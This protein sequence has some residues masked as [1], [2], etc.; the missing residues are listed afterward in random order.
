M[1]NKVAAFAVLSVCFLLPFYFATAFVG[2]TTRTLLWNKNAFLHNKIPVVLPPTRQQNPSSSS[3]VICHGIPK[4]FRWLTDQYPNINRRLSEGLTEKTVVDNFYLDCNGLIHPATHNNSDEFVVLDETA[5]FKKIFGYVDRLYKLVQPKKLLY[6]AVD[7]TCPR[8][9]INQQRSRRFRSGK[10][11]EQ[12]AA[13]IVAKEGKLPEG[14]RFDSNCITP[15]T[16][17]MLKLTLS[18]QKWI[19]YK[20]ATD[21]FWIANGATVIFSGPDVPGEGE[22]KVMDYIREYQTSTEYQPNT[23]HILYG[24]D[25]DLI[26]L[27][28]VTHEPKFMLLREKMSVVMA[29]KRGKGKKRDMLEYMRDDFELLELSALRDMFQIQFRKFADFKLLRVPYDV[30]RIIDDF[31]FMCML[32]GNDFIPHS[33]HLDID[34]GALSLMLSLYIDLLPIWGGYLTDKDAIHPD[35]LEQ[36][37]HATAA[38]EQEHFARRAF[39]ENEPGFALP[40][41]PQEY[42]GKY[43]ETADSWSKFPGSTV[44]PT[45]ELK[46]NRQTTLKRHVQFDVDEQ[47]NKKHDKKV[48][49]RF[50]KKHPDDNDQQSY[51]DFYYME[52]L[53][54]ST[55]QERR[56]MARDYLE[57]L[58]WVLHYYHK[59]C[60]SWEWFFPHLYAPLA[61]DMVNLHEFYND[62]TTTSE[63]FCAFQ[64]E[65]EKNLPPLAQLLSVLPPQSAD[66][67][68]KPLAELMLDPNSPLAEY[69][70]RDFSVDQNGKRMSWEAVVKI[71]FIN[72]KVLLETMGAVLN[73]TNVERMLTNG[74]KRRNMEGEIHY[75][76]HHN[77]EGSSATKVKRPGNYNG[78]SGPRPSKR[79]GAE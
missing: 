14:K 60:P 33:P 62:S 47:E 50:H 78:V 24:L 51:R 41:Y 39:E 46:R 17:F 77:K 8:A 36:F 2:T 27:G 22:H 58:H 42:Y 29:G 21:P 49:S 66:L 67:L 38:Y 57:G 59:G 16:D 43:Y 53:N 20:Q 18:F 32:V 35:R 1:T 79:R 34:N 19:E 9:K 30:N 73:D 72:S 37:L 7:G 52:K 11:A 15:G 61:S 76:P 75:Y 56:A 28:L 5:M 12:L 4:M 6:L 3:L 10:E 13:T 54:V 23:Q 64:F 40:T 70:P 68:P 26:M 63:G 65:K 25:A 45:M 74:E 31:V 69:Y 71:P 44:L 55:R 48:I